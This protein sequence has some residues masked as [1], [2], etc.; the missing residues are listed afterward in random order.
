MFPPVF[1]VFPVQQSI[2]NSSYLQPQQQPV[3]ARSGKPETSQSLVMRSQTPSAAQAQLISSMPQQTLASAP[4]QTTQSM[5]MQQPNVPAQAYYGYSMTTPQMPQMGSVGVQVQSPHTNVLRQQAPSAAE[6][7]FYMSST[8]V[9]LQS[10]Q[11]KSWQQPN[12]MQRGQ[13]CSRRCRRHSQV[14]PTH[15]FNLTTERLGPTDP[16]CRTASVSAGGFP[17]PASSITCAASEHGTGARS[18]TT[19][20]TVQDPETCR[21]GPLERCHDRAAPLPIS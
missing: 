20:A 11:I 13:T 1:P 5:M 21:D 16:E 8:V 6:A 7:N 15:S 12:L 10:Y 18:S 19:T 14:R 3:V 17:T 4:S 2:E 9:Q